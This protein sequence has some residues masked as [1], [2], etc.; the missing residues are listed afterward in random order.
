MTRRRSLLVAA[1]AAAAAAA[2]AWPGAARAADPDV[3]G[4]VFVAQPVRAPVAPERVTPVPP[5]VPAG[6][7]EQSGEVTVG[8]DRAAA[9]WLDPLDVVRVRHTAALRFA[10]VIGAEGVRARLDEPGAAIERGVTYLSQPPGRG[11]VW[12]IWADRAAAIRVERPVARDGRLIWDDTLRALLDWV[13]RG[14]ARVAIPVADGASAAALALDADARLG[15][16]IEAAWPSAKL[17]KAVRAWRK[18]ARDRG[19]DRDPAARRAAARDHAA[20]R[21]ARHGRRRHGRRSARAGA[22]AVPRVSGAGPWKLTLVGP[23]VL[24]VEARAVLPPITAAA[25]RP[26]RRR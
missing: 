16:Q 7:P 5:F 26:S 4:V 12:I 6:V 25:T 17:R 15:A 22:A 20:R 1:V 3:T 13:D 21:P 23:G 10:R 24:R 18:A 2:A 11:D 19:A 9:L 14:G 8:P